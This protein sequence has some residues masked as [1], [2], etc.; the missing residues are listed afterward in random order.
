MLFK[1]FQII[2]LA[3]VF[4]L[5]YFF[6]HIHPQRKILN[7]W[8]NER[9][10]I[11]IGLFNLLFVFMPASALVW[12]LSLID[13]K[14]IGLLQQAVLPYWVQIIITL[15][16]LDMWMYAW[17]RLNHELPFLWKFHRLHHTDQKMN[18]TTAIRFHI[19]E[20]LFS[21][22]GKAIV[23]IIAGLQ[24][25]PVL[26]YEILFFTAVVIHHSNIYISQATDKIYSRFFSSPGMH[27]IHHSIHVS[28]R[29]SNYGS[30]FSFWDKLFRTSVYKD[31]NTITFG[32]N[33]EINK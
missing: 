29:N 17:H 16:V 9:Y 20:L 31:F 33:E 13:E 27:R 2:I 11:L 5:Q 23:C 3:A 22:P 6:E 14:N 28:E 25:T 32:V 19:L 15:I 12:L 8:K 18:S 30:V 7:S 24:Y 26:I 4:L 21:Y 1:H 10:N